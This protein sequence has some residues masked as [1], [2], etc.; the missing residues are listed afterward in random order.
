MCCFYEESGSEIAYVR[1]VSTFPLQDVLDG[2]VS[3]IQTD[4]RNKEP[5]WDGFLFHISDGTNIS[6]T[7]RFNITILVSLSFNL[8]TY[9]LISHVVWHV[10]LTLS[11]KY[12]HSSPL[13]R[14][15][16]F[17]FSFLNLP[18][19][20]HLVQTRAYMAVFLLNK[21]LGRSLTSSL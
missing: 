12:C 3:Y 14:L 18:E 6:P 21:P 2:H 11:T 8:F 7:H 9:F 1:N 15:E 4:H 17:N 20:K 10:R 5:A 13:R 16:C 19:D